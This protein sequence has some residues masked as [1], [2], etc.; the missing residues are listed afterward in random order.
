[1]KTNS[2]VFIV[3]TT[4]LIIFS[5]ILVG[6]V[7][8]HPQIPEYDEEVIKAELIERLLTNENL[9]SG[10]T[11]RY[12]FYSEDEIRSVEFGKPMALY[13]IPDDLIINNYQ[14]NKFEMLFLDLWVTPLIVNDQIR[15]LAF[16]TNKDGK[17]VLHGFGS[18]NIAD[19]LS[20]INTFDYCD[21]NQGLLVAVSRGSKFLIK[22]GD[23]DSAFYPLGYT[24][25]VLKIENIDFIYGNSL[26]CIFY[27]KLT[28][29]QVCETEI[30]NYTNLN[31]IKILN[32]NTPMLITIFNNN[33]SKGLLSFYTPEGKIVTKIM[34]SNKETQ[35][36]ITQSGLFIYIFETE[37]GEVQNGKVLIKQ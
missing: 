6:Q 15:S 1:M 19:E 36:Q 30:A 5:T 13:D 7:I 27:S 21:D 25:L 14:Q 35:L 32:T 12:G 20:E 37:K 18:K 31:S 2:L 8:E 22:D 4:H 33:E 10:Y 3:F 28:G 24:G 34:I 9:I 26:I 16:L 23:N 29:E 17:V 11:E